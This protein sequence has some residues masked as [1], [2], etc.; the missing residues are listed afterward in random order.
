MKNAAS[1]IGKFIMPS[2]YDE[3]EFR[4]LESLGRTQEK[5]QDFLTPLIES[6][7]SEEIILA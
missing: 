5:Y 3:L 4:D 1:G 2:L 7:L 6:C